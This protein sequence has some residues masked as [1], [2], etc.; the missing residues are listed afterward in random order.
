MASR[1]T[2]ILNYYDTEKDNIFFPLL[3][4]MLNVL[5]HLLQINII[6]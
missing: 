4:D 2:I 5:M 6:P 3:I 1:C